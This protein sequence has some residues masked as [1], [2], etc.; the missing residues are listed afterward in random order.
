MGAFF[1]KK[2]A[3]LGRW[4]LVIDELDHPLHIAASDLLEL[5][6]LSRLID[7]RSLGKINEEVAAA[8]PVLFFAVLR[9]LAA[10]QHAVSLEARPINTQAHQ[11]DVAN[12][13]IVGVGGKPSV[14]GP[15][16]ALLHPLEPG[17]VWW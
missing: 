9:V 3:R 8:K 14:V 17:A 6:E 15:L 12:P 13:L 5:G 2:T 11:V 4:I 7:L 1:Y 16:N 10:N